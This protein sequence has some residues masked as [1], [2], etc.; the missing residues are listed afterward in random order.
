[1]LQIAYMDLNYLLFFVLY[2]NAHEILG[3]VL[4]YHQNIYFEV[5]K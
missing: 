5:I 3:L 2:W 4:M 1:M